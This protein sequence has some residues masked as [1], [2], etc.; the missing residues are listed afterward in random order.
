MNLLL[1]TIKNERHL[2]VTV[3]EHRL[4]LEN[5]AFEALYKK[6]YRLGRVLLGL[7]HNFKLVRDFVDESDEI[8]SPKYQLVYPLGS[9]HDLDGSEIRCL[10]HAAV[11]QS[12]SRHSKYLF[13]CYGGTAVEMVKFEHN[14]YQYSTIRL[15]NGP[16][17][18]EVYDRLCQLVV[19]DI[20]TDKVPQKNGLKLRM[21]QDELDVWKRCVDGESI[22]L[23]EISNSLKSVKLLN[24]AL[25]L[26]GILSHKILKLLLQ[27]RVRVEY[28]CNPFRPG[29]QLAVPYRYKDVP[30]KQSDFAHP[31]VCIGLTFATYYQCG[32][33]EEQLLDVF[34]RLSRMSD[35]SSY[36]SRWTEDMDGI[37]NLRSYTSVNLEDTELFRDSVFPLFRYHLGVIDFWLTKV[38]LPVQAKQYKEKI[39]ATA[40][41]LFKSNEL[42]PFCNA[43]TTGFSGT[44]DL[45]LVL[46]P[47]VKQIN[48]EAL[49]ATNGIQLLNILRPE[50]SAYYALDSQHLSDNHTTNMIL[51]HLQTSEVKANVVLDA[52]ALVLHLSNEKFARAWLKQRTDCE[53]CAFFM[54]DKVVYIS[55]H[56]WNRVLSFSGSQFEADMSKCL[57]YLDDEHTRGSD[58]KLPLDARAVVTLG[59]GMN[60]DKLVQ[61][62]MRM[63]QIGRG[64]QLAFV[65][66]HDVHL[67]LEQMDNDTGSETERI[68][69]II[70][71]TL[72]NTS[73]RICDLVPY[74]V[75]QDVCSQQKLEALSQ[76]YSRQA[77]SLYGRQ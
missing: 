5:K 57:L 59:K 43:I 69:N 25:I 74:F 18:K 62:C 72:K 19:K 39:T 17:L 16:L 3:P 33:S 61:A 52:G 28:G 29:Y 44:D 60:K 21:K 67:E 63:R 56:D 65:A 35:A 27:K 38:V 23:F 24:S 45:S 12:V 53:A 34:R 49:S 76:H 7:I 71:W 68:V 10:I 20:L 46:P 22:K 40:V 13:D 9:P 55:K 1:T 30:S 2:L 50:N 41:D 36:Y 26:R 11:L 66:S 64:Q 58:F 8:G 54:Q 4:S 6:D 31:D 77:V 37:G 47:T 51:M 15:L 32:L 14:D 73:K 70:H 42:A 48:M 75:N